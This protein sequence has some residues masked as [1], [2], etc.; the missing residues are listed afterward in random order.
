MKVVGNIPVFLQIALSNIGFESSG[1]FSLLEDDFGEIFQAIESEVSRLL[2][3]LSEIDED[4]L[5][6][7][8]IEMKK[9][10]KASISLVSPFKLNLG[11]KFLIKAIANVFK[12]S[13]KR[14]NVT[15]VSEGGRDFPVPVSSLSDEEVLKKMMNIAVKAI[16]QFGSVQ[17]KENLGNMKTEK[18]DEGY[19]FLCPLK[20]CR[21]KA[22]IRGLNQNVDSTK[23][24]RH[25]KKVH[26]KR[27]ENSEEQVLVGHDDSSSSTSSTVTQ[28]SSGNIIFSHIN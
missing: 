18:T 8:N 21:I 3:N 16:E 26:G 4:H 11:H 14:R 25:I 5:E 6:S 20:Q 19:Y 1:S 10:H 17:M 9:F 28:T 7:F 12:T 24:E 2:I 23:Y 22:S 13:K 15:S 27:F